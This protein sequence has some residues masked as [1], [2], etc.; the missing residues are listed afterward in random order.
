MAAFADWLGLKAWRRAKDAHW[1]E[2][3]RLLWPARSAAVSNIIVIPLVLDQAHRLLS[4]ETIYFWEL[5]GIAA[6]AG[7][8]FGKLSL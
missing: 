1:T 6:F 3:A 7:S 2:R 4:P 8:L 5:N